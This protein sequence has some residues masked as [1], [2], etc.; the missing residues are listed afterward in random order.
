VFNFVPELA[1]KFFSAMRG[2]D[3]ATMET[4]L[5]DFFYPF[6]ALRERQPGYAV[7]AIKAGV[8]LRGFDAG[9]V[10]LPLI[11]LTADEEQILAKLIE[12]YN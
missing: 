10:R 8:R 4:L 5:Q 9:K 7:S 6:M 2:N 3:R 1:L 12:P 11:D